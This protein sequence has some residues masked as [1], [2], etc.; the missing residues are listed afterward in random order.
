MANI[1]IDLGTPITR[2]RRARWEGTCLLDDDERALLPS[3]VHYGTDGV[4]KSSGTPR[5]PRRGVVTE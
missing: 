2:C 4:P 1:G 5:L 3:A